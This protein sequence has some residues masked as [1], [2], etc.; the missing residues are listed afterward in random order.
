M[1]AKLPALEKNI[2]KYRALQMVL[3]IHQVESLRTFIIGSIRSSESLLPRDSN[4]RALPEGVKRPME[5]A[6]NI[7]VTKEIIT[8]KESEDL[9]GIIEVRNQ[10]GHKVH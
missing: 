10:I 6:L 3:L 4:L 5:K 9:Q 2:L 8:E 1:R 7:L